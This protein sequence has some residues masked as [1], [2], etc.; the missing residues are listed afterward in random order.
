MYLPVRVRNAHISDSIFNAADL[1]V[2]TAMQA[3]RIQLPRKPAEASV[4]ENTTVLYVLSVS[5][6]KVLF[7]QG[8]V[9]KMVFTSG[10]GEEL[11]KE[12]DEYVDRSV[13]PPALVD[14]K[15]KPYNG[16]PTNFTGGKYQL[17]NDVELTH[18]LLGAKFKMYSLKGVIRS[19]HLRLA[20]K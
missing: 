13:L 3:Y 14:L 11:L 18:E 4:R 19:K 15:A 8:V 9:K 20:T 2:A 10:D 17:V 6:D 1:V 16:M 5:T 7:D 12:L